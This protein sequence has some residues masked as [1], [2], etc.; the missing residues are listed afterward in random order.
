LGR[1]CQA[2]CLFLF[3][4]AMDINNEIG[5]GRAALHIAACSFAARVGRWRRIILSWAIALACCSPVSAQSLQ[6]PGFTAY[7]N[8]NSSP[9]TS[10]PV[11]FDSSG[12]NTVITGISG[13]VIRVYRLV[14]VP[15]AN[16][17]V[18]IQDGNTALTGG[19]AL[20]A[21]QPLT[22]AF[23]TAPWFICQP[24]DNFVINLGSGETVAGIVYYTQG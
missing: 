2:A 1:R 24:G 22:F 14:L 15:S 3:E 20:A 16:V 18:T 9:L 5:R 4:T 13:K 7:I 19:M 12:A 23:D 8:G 6:Q 11:S 17:T 10:A 21:N